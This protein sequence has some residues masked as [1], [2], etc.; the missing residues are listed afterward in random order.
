MI[1]VSMMGYRSARW[2]ALMNPWAH[3]ADKGYQT[4]HAL[5]AIGDG[6]WFG[7]GL[8]GGIQKLFYLPEAH[9]DFI[10]SILAEEFGFIGMLLVLALYGWLVVRAFVIG[11]QA[12]K[13]GKHFGAYVAYGIGFWMGFQ[14]ILHIGVNLAVLPPKGLTLPLMSYGG[15]SLMVTLAAMALLM[16]VYRETQFALLGLP[17]RHAVGVQTSRPRPVRRRAARG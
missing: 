12:D 17:E 8:G 1:P 4:V 6:G 15:S 16:R 10:F 11:F 2:D 13:V 3:E 9:N 5:M 7:N 14:V